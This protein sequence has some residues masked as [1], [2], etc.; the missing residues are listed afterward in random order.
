VAQRDA[1]LRHLGEGSEM[2]GQ[3]RKLKPNGQEALIDLLRSL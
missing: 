2:T 1:I 3:F